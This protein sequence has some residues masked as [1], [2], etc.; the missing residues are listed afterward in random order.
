[1]FIVSA[2]QACLIQSGTF[3]RPIKWKGTGQAV[4]LAGRLELGRIRVVIPIG[5]TAYSTHPW[6]PTPSELIGHFELVNRETL[7]QEVKKHESADR[8]SADAEE[9]G[10][11][12]L[13]AGS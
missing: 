2:T 7:V 11:K 3:A 12:L 13:S 9:R 8:G 1:M 10:V 5:A 6:L 4:D